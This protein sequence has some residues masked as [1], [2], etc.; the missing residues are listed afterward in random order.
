MARGSYKRT[1]LLQSSKRAFLSALNNFNNI[2]NTYREESALILMSNAVELIAKATLLKL[3]DAI[4]GTRDP[5]K[6][7]SG[8]QALWRLFHTHA[9]I[10]DLEHQAVQQII[11]LRN[12]AVHD[13]LPEVDIDVLHYLIFA[14]YQL[15]KKLIRTSFRNH[16]DIFRTSLLSISTESNLTY[17]DSVDGLLRA[18]K[19]SETQRRLLYLLERGVSYSGTRYISQEEFEQ[20][21]KRERNRRLVNRGAL[22]AFLAK[23]EL[24]KVVFVQAPRNHAIK[25]DISKGQATQREVLP[26]LVKKTDINADYPYILTTLAEKI[27]AGRNRVLAKINE[28]GMK[29]NDKYH[30]AVQISRSQMAHHK[31]SDAAY[32]FLCDKLGALK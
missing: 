3:G 8:E 30:Q 1:R 27:G 31:Y 7:I 23:A 15:Y 10:T 4:V 13:V 2:S 25:I 19:G 28:L 26:V 22:G 17:A 24:L 21:F 16:E 11:S 5:A 18:R 6:T 14:A 32:Q 9:L 12:E 20:R 29:G